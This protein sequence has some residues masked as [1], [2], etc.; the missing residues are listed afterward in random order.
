MWNYDGGHIFYNCDDEEKIKTASRLSQ[1]QHDYI[2]GFYLSHE[3]EESCH[4]SK[5]VTGLLG[6]SHVRPV[7]TLQEV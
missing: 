6:V 4:H 7:A 3:F 1:K 2:L 5:R